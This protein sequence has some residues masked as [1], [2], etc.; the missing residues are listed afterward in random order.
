MSKIRFYFPKILLTFLLIF[1]LI[2]S[3]TAL[4]VQQKAL[5][6]NTFTQ[7]ITQQEL[8]T[9]AYSSLDAYFQSRCNSSGI[10][11]EVFMNSLNEEF[12]ENAILSNDS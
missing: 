12:L 10:P 4:L 5:A 2:G 8:G 11:K 7:V 6:K 1:L 3:E 9:K